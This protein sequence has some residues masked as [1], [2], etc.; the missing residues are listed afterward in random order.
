MRRFLKYLI[1]GLAVPAVPLVLLGANGCDTPAETTADT[2]AG[3]ADT[4][5]PEAHALATPYAVFVPNM[6]SPRALPSHDTGPAAPVVSVTFSPRE[7]IAQG[8]AHFMPILA[9]YPDLAI[10]LASGELGHVG[11]GLAPLA[12]PLQALAGAPWLM[13]DGRIVLATRARDAIDSAALRAANPAGIDFER[14]GLGQGAELTTRPAR[15]EPGGL[16]V[17]RSAL[18]VD[19][20]PA[21]QRALIGRTVRI[22]DAHGERCVARVTGLALES[23]LVHMTG[24][25]FGED[26]KPIVPTHTAADVVADGQP[27]LFAA[28]E[29]IIGT[30]ADCQSG[31]WAAPIGD[32]P[33]VQL[34]T[35]APVDRALLRHA[36]RA[37]RALPEWRARQHDYRHFFANPEDQPHANP[38]DARWDTYG[39]VQGP[40]V[41]RLVAR[42][43]LAEIVTVSANTQ[44]GCGDPGQQMTALFAVTR[45][46]DKVTLA[47][48]AELPW[49]DAPSGVADWNGDGTLELF[50]NDSSAFRTFP[51]RDVFHVT[52]KRTA[53]DNALTPV[54]AF[55][56]P[57]LT[58]YGCGC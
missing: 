5:L 54:R 35:A 38:G 41:A 4:S 17:A 36:V 52:P 37:F 33:Q 18:R 20:V 21:A 6:S 48:I 49:T 8:L 19:A 45:D 43:G 40:S 47:A 55:S 25:D 29:P 31:L 23:Q 58:I 26:D 24:E 39:N 22:F 53:D 57:D 27:F 34:F 28:L 56:V 10:A 9:A 32:Q 42:S 50:Y 11:D 12:A 3:D 1:R 14:I 30:V 16:F 15:T 13:H 51:S 46:G 44:G 2:A 7:R